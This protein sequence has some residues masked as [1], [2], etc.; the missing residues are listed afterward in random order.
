MS[1]VAKQSFGLPINAYFIAGLTI[2]VA[3]SFIINLE[4]GLQ[5][6]LFE[7]MTLAVLFLIPKVKVIGILGTVSMIALLVSNFIR[8]FIL[9][10]DFQ[11][12]SYP[13]R[14]NINIEDLEQ[15]LKSTNAATLG[16]SIGFI[17][18][19]NL[20]YLQRKTKPVQDNT[21]KKKPFLLKHIYTILFLCTSL[22]LLSCTLFFVLG[23]G[24]KGEAVTSPLAFLSRL[25]PKDL[26]FGVIALYFFKYSEYLKL[27]QKLLLISIA[28]LFC[29]NILAT[30]SKSFVMIFAFA[31]LSWL[32][33][34]DIRVPL[35]KM[36]FLL[37][38]GSAILGVSFILADSI[39]MA[40]NL[41]LGYS[42]ML[43]LTAAV[44][45]EIS[46][47]QIISDITSRFVG[48]DGT[49][50][51]NAVKDS[52][53]SEYKN[54]LYDIY[55]L[56]ATLTRSFGNIVPGFSLKGNIQSGVAVGR[57]ISEVPEQ[58][59]YAG[60]LGSVASMELMT[61]GSTFI[62]HLGLGVASGLY[63]LFVSK[64]KDD[65]LAYILTF[66]FNF[67]L[68]F[69]IMS[70]NFDMMIALLVI[71]LVLLPSYIFLTRIITSLK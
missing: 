17:F 38:G 34:S 28:A 65:D 8:P 45:Q 53:S 61:R 14:A 7:L 6:V 46:L 71:K 41:G 18:I 1:T 63:G 36:F 43:K 31:Y 56:P 50:V 58:L 19:S 15:A 37:I 48:M 57:Y 42:S 49:L 26:I 29:I 47:F 21:I 68:L 64:V 70:G 2:L 10:L 3:F 16:Y 13:N 39:K 66:F 27:W 25:I 20:Y 60:A 55:E 4:V 44:I 62:G 9:S 24:M 67:F 40:S 69:T 11:S 52:W 35:L 12:F 5:Y 51:F 54:A 22:V 23:I 59:N 33:Y 30:G 32:L